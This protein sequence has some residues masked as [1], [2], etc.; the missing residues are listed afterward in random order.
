MKQNQE[1]AEHLRL[2]RKA[3]QSRHRTV[4]QGGPAVRE[5]WK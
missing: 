1:I 2:W 3:V 4:G 5:V